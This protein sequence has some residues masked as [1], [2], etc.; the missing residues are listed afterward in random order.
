[1]VQNSQQQTEQQQRRAERARGQ[2]SD[3]QP[4]AGG[5]GRVAARGGGDLQADRPARAGA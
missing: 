3:D 4:E 1:V 5:Q 2:R